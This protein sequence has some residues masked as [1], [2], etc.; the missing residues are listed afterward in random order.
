MNNHG[1]KRER[2]YDCTRDD[3]YPNELSKENYRRKKQE[4]ANIEGTSDDNVNRDLHHDV[5]QE[6]I[7]PGM[8]TYYR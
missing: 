2:K 3:T 8:H 1:K 6:E 4:R 5:Q 7:Q